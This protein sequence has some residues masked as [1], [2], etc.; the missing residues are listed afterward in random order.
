[1]KNFCTLLLLFPGFC[2]LAQ[3]E[4]DLDFLIHPQ[5]A[6]EAGLLQANNVWRMERKESQR[7]DI[8]LV[9][10][11][12][13]DEKG[14]LAQKTDYSPSETREEAITLRY[15]AQDRVVEIIDSIS[16][17]NQDSM[18]LQMHLKLEYAGEKISE[19]SGTYAGNQVEWLADSGRLGMA[20]HKTYK[21]VYLDDRNHIRKQRITTNGSQLVRTYDYTGDRRVQM[22][23]KKY[24]DRGNKVFDSKTSYTY[25][26]DG[27]PEREEQEI[28]IYRE[29]GEKSMRK[30]AHLYEYNE[31][32]QL[33]H[34]EMLED[35]MPYIRKSYSYKQGLLRK[36]DNQENYSGGWETV[37]TTYLGYRKK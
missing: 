35:E 8:R 28:T 11:R 34:Y 6:E 26:A 14:R 29:G 22:V 27:L 36:I 10:V 30:V 2:A 9:E 4:V 12:E 19:F 1:M 24:D 7:P 21:R 33:T 17:P 37:S 23:T 5:S 32:G 18:M 25:R 16:A 13:F 31:E 15:D 3:N 20:G